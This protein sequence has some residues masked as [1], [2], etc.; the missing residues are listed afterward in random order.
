MA[1]KL[2]GIVQDLK[3]LLV[4]RLSIVPAE[5]NAWLVNGYDR[6]LAVKI[7]GTDVL[8]EARKTILIG[9]KAYKEQGL[10]TLP[11]PASRD[12]RKDPV[13]ISYSRFGKEFRE[14]VGTGCGC[15]TCSP[16]GDK[17]RGKQCRRL[18]ELSKIGRNAD[19]SG[20]SPESKDVDTSDILSI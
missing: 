17:K 13:T 11:E 16:T 14:R 4:E 2:I 20:S 9:C 15:S 12:L 5:L 1:T 3:P 8:K 19:F 10:S 6:D 7:V 18:V